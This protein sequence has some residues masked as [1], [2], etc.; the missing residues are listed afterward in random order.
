MMYAF[1]IHY[2][3]GI[4]KHHNVL[5]CVSGCNH[6]LSYDNETE[7]EIDFPKSQYL[8]ITSQSCSWRVTYPLDYTISLSI[9]SLDIPANRSDHCNA[10]FLEISGIEGNASIIKLCG[11]YQ[12]Y[13]LHSLSN[14]VMIVLKLANNVTKTTGFRLNFK[15]V[16][17]EGKACMNVF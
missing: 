1:Y 13:K 5:L 17:Y 8:D 11:E 2:F 4:N 16:L 15:G 7:V 3:Y 10:Q 6:T 14:Q 9:I 12:Q